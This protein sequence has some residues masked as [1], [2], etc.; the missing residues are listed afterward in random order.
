MRLNVQGENLVVVRG[1]RLPEEETAVSWLPEQIK[2]VT[3]TFSALQLFQQSAYRV[4]P[5]FALSADNIDDVIAICRQVHGLPLG[6]ELAASWMEMLS[7][8]EIRHEID[9]NLDFLQTETQDVPERQ[10]SLRAVF[11]YSW[12]LMNADEQQLFPQ[13]ALFQGGF[14][15][16]AAQAVAQT[17]LRTLMRLV[18]KSLVRRE[19]N[20]RFVIHELLRQYA[21]EIIQKDAETLFNFRSRHSK[22]YLQSLAKQSKVMQGPQQREAYDAVEQE[23]S[24]IQAAWFWGVAHGEFEQG[25]AALSGLFNY[26]LVRSNLMF[27][28]GV[29][30]LVLEDVCEAAAVDLEAGR[31]NTHAQR[32]HGALV[33]LMSF[34]VSFDYAS[35]HPKRLSR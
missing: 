1:M 9:N 2:T 6:I 34:I 7:P 27:M 14:S 26:Y 28:I 15:R 30:E 24:N 31:Q 32:L 25:L 19:E 20:G 21:T 12:E 18:N 10:R 16:E 33:A 13:L 4:Q 8:A 23:L 35:S 5:G 11:N 22:H 29:L 17:N 3:T